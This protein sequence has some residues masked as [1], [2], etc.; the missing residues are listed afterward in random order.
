MSVKIWDSAL[1]LLKM[2][3]CTDEWGNKT[4]KNASET[5]II[6]I[7]YVLTSFFFYEYFLVYFFGLYSCAHTV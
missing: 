4:V 6:T 1:Y 2:Q 3:W 7:F 5:T